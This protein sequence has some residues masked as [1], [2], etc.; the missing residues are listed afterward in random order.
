MKS[1]HVAAIMLAGFGFTGACLAQTPP[2]AQAPAT[3]A[4]PA[5]P[6]PSPQIV[7]NG[8]LDIYYDY[9]FNRPPGSDPTG[10][11]TR[12]FDYKADMFAIGLAELQVSRATAANSRFGWNIKLAYGPTV[13][14]LTSPGDSDNK[15]ILQAY[16]EYLVPM[17]SK[18]VTVDIGKF[19][20]FLGQ[21]VI[22]PSG[23]WNYS[24]SL[25]FQYFIPY[26]H[27]GVHASVPLTSTVAL[28]GYL[29]NG[30]NDV[31]F[32]SNHNLA[33]GA[34]LVFTPNSNDSLSFNALTSNEPVTLTYTGGEGGAGT[35]TTQSEPKTVLEGIWTH[36][37]NASLSGAV[38]LNYDFGTSATAGTTSPAFTTGNWDAFGVA[39]YLK[40]AFKSGSYFALRGEYVTDPDGFLMGVGNVNAQEITA[41]YSLQNPLF[42]GS[43]L[44]FELR[45]DTA[46]QPGLFAGTSSK[47]QTTL[48][49]SHIFTF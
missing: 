30:W 6:P 16:G 9:N 27:A 44:R 15:N 46:S 2:A 38:D 40:Y 10:P 41:T 7:W 1:L 37:F 36:N 14:L 12:N 31:S 23:N 42:K 32:D 48:S 47:N 26:Y 45:Y 17:G 18:D 25:L 39:A 29:V 20:T 4:T 28:T 34:S 24:R 35:T 8:A 21:E 33:Y 3:P 5:A 19:A 13:D 49:V 43:E 11:G 22:E